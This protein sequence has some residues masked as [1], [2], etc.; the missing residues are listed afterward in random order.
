MLPAK[1]D[2]RLYRLPEVLV[3]HLK[4]F[5]YTA[6]GGGRYTKLQ[7]VVTFGC[8]LRL[9]GK[10]REA[11]QLRFRNILLATCQHRT[12]HVPQPS[13]RSVSSASW[14][15]ERVACPGPRLSVVRV[16]V[17]NRPHGPRLV[18]PAPSA[19]VSLLLP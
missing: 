3:L 13:S 14:A 5:T 9:E 8:M 12:W 17:P 2:V 6:A 15:Y 10:V 19:R 11:S 7:K 4:R 1:K 18:A 16:R